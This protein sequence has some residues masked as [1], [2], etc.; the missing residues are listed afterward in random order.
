MKVYKRASDRSIRKKLRSPGHPPGWQRE[1]LCR[2]W[3]AIA[4]GRT[5]EE[6]ALDARVSAPVGV[7]WYRSAGGMPPTHL[8]PSAG[9]VIGRYLTFPE[10]ED[11]AIELAKGSGIR[12]IALKLG[13]SPSTISRE[14]RRNAAT[15]GGNFDYRAT[16]AQW[17]S[18]RSA[19]HPKPSKLAA[20]AALRT[21]VEERL[22]GKVANAEGVEFG[23]PEVVWKGRRAVHRQSRRW[24]MAWSPEQIAHRLRL[25]FPEDATMRISHEAI[26]QSLYIQGRGAL[27]GADS[28]FAFGA[29]P[30]SSAGASSM[31]RQAVH[32]KCHNDQRAAAR[33]R[34]QSCSGALGRRSHP[35]HGKLGDRNAC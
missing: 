14:I 20:N 34:G 6:A 3:Q 24:S 21:Y 31:S 32:Y 10:R 15:R 9:P 17:H 23:R 1:N 29:F 22:A 25:D 2:F 28:L 30:A 18:D 4:A 13:G 16:A 19:R 27:P 7:R 12:S 26:Y 8:A 35:W 11:I 33:D 5:S